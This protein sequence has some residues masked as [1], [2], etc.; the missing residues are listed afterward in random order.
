M[1]RT[2][3]EPRPSM[4]QSSQSTVEINLNGR[5]VKRQIYNPVAKK[6]TAKPN[7]NVSRNNRTK[8]GYYQPGVVALFEIR[9]YQKSTEMLIKKAPF[10]R[11]VKE[12]LNDFKRDCRLQV[13]CL[14]M[15]QVCHFPIKDKVT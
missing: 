8:R 11:L 15:L 12:I 2:K 5:N 1:T 3:A 14:E 9:K 13:V 6:S 4:S 10:Q 7:N